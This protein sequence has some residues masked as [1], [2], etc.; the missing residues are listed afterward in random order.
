MTCLLGMLDKLCLLLK[1]VIKI[2]LQVI[3][4]VTSPKF[5]PFMRDQDCECLNVS[6]VSRYGK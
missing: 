1:Y 3:L 4:G 2:H 6:P 5:I